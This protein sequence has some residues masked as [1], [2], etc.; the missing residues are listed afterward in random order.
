M[1]DT[2]LHD[3]EKRYMVGMIQRRAGEIMARVIADRQPEGEATALEPHLE[4]IYLYYF[5]DVPE[6]EER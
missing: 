5:G 6:R 2:Q 1:P 4:D 3:L